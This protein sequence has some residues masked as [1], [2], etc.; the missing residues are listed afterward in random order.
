MGARAADVMQLLVWVAGGALVGAL[1]FLLLVAAVKVLGRH[2][3]LLQSLERRTRA[4]LLVTLLVAG[5]TVGYQIPEATDRTA[6]YGI[7][8]H[9]LVL[10]LVACVGW[11]FY[12]SCGLIADLTHLRVEKDGRDSQRLQTQSQVLQRVLQSVVV[13]ATII[14]ML[15]TFPGA[16][17]PLASMLGAAG[18]LSIVTG[19]A[20]QSTLG[21][22]FAGIQLAFTDA[23]RVGDTL[24]VSVAGSEEAGTVEELTLTYVVLSVWNKRRILLPSSYFTTQPF[25]N[26]TKAGTE[27]LG[28]V[29][30]QFDYPVPVDRLRERVQKVL[31]ASPQWDRRVWN[32]QVTS[33]DSETVTVRIVVSAANPGDRWDLEC[34]V[35]ENILAWV[36]AEVPWAL[37]RTRTVLEKPGLAG[38]DGPIQV[39]V[40]VEKPLRAV[41]QSAPAQELHAD[42][43]RKKSRR[44][45]LLGIGKQDS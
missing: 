35:R 14:T 28:G 24:T 43:I 8:L 2:A 31:S 44:F 38:E 33:S 16:R 19:L 42:Q 12:A 5:A 4:A 41:D 36:C 29:T 27:Q 13:V 34:Q 26:W 39:E 40:P 3:Q 21:N 25:E 7:T 45:A 30:L 23:I 9:A 32:V 11:F 17:A 10:I 37:P 6:L 22:M 18:L 20:A 15:L 1:V